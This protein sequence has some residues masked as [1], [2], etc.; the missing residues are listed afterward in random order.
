MPVAPDVPSWT[1]LTA[2]VPD[3]LDA[4]EAWALHGAA[5]V[6]FQ[7]EMDTWG[8]PD[9]MYPAWYLIADLQPQPYS[10]RQLLV[11]VPAGTE[12]PTADDVVG[13]A[14]I[15][16]PLQDNTHVAHAEVFVGPANTG[17]GVGTALLAAVE[18]LAAEHGRTSILAYSTHAGE[19]PAGTP[20]V[21]E[22]PTGSGRIDP[23][24]AAVRI[25]RRRGYELEQAER[26]SVL[27]LPVADEL[28]DRLQAEAAARAGTDYRLVSWTG[29]APDE[30]VDQVAVLET[31]MSTDAPS[32]GLDL[33][34]ATW[35]ADRVRSWESQTHESQH[36]F[37]LVAAEHVPTGTLAAFT[38]L[39]WPVDHEEIVFQEDTLV[40]R[41]HRGRRLGMLVKA[42]NLRRLRELRPGAL[43][44]HTWNAEENSYML[45]INVALGFRPTGVIGSWQKRTGPA[46]AEVSEPA[47]EAEPVPAQGA[48]V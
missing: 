26:Y 9:L 39:R 45:A 38:V 3:N 42:E 48:G 22:P 34:E 19:P 13:M 41:E 40:L 15:G 10:I 5:R 8:Y 17:Q 21:L 1:V 46:P 23:G 6:T 4:P 16:I 32:A 35:D 11:A 30:W 37:S 7:L 14:K 20:G 47:Q 25:A 2:P 29:R 28:L 36:E 31:R 12:N 24:A 43:R 44:V 33:A 18:D 27:R